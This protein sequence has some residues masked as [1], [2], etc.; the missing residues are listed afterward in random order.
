MYVCVANHRVRSATG[1]NP[2]ANRCADIVGYFLS[3]YQAAVFCMCVC[4]YFYYL[5]RPA[6]E[7]EEEENG[8]KKGNNA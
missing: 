2:T 8:K 5:K 7:V 6:Q 3:G 1:V 4:C